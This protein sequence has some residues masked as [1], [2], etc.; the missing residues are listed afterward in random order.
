MLK[1]FKKFSNF[2]WAKLLKTSQMMKFKLVCVVNLW[3]NAFKNEISVLNCRC[4]RQEGDFN[5]NV[6]K[7]KCNEKM[8]L[9]D[10]A[11]N[12]EEYKRKWYNINSMDIDMLL[13]KVN[14]IEKTRIF[15]WKED[16]C[17]KKKWRRG[18]WVVFE[19]KLP[20]WRF[21]WYSMMYTDVQS[22]FC[23]IYDCVQSAQPVKWSPRG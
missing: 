22:V 15:L 1:W 23:Y 21:G 7:K 13:N 4:D 2:W 6:K 3:A 20:L 18:W 19:N 17:K 5:T 9:L 16:V 11:L 14:C 8:L 12:D 10:M